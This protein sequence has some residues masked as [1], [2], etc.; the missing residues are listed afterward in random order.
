MVTL[1]KYVAFGCT[2]FSSIYWTH[3]VLHFL[4]NF[5][6]SFQLFLLSFKVFQRNSSKK[7]FFIGI[8]FSYWYMFFQFYDQIQFFSFDQ[9]SKSC[10][11]FFCL[12][13]KRLMQKSF[14]VYILSFFLT[15]WKDFLKYFL[16]CVNQLHFVL[17]SLKQFL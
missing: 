5:C 7:S 3:I 4:Y 15:K 2:H 17:I 6:L 16:S 10:L 13:I 1:L 9:C 12:Q 8:I 14:L 11:D